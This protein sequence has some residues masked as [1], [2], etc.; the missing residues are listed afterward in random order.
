MSQSLAS[1]SSACS[2]IHSSF[3]FLGRSD[4][5]ALHKV[6]K[7]KIYFL[8]AMCIRAYVLIVVLGPPFF[9]VTM[10][11]RNFTPIENV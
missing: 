2:S 4:N 1:Y 10:P 5:I 3:L 7:M 9:F 6:A 8:L 11:C